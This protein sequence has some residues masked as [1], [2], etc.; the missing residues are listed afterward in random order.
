MVPVQ[1]SELTILLSLVRCGRRAANGGGNQGQK[2]EWRVIPWKVFWTVYVGAA[3]NP[4]AQRAQNKGP[5]GGAATILG[6]NSPLGPGSRLH[7]SC[8]QHDVE[9]GEP[10]ANGKEE[11]SVETRY[12]ACGI[13][14]AKLTRK[15]KRLAIRL[16]RLTLEACRT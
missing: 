12:S 13:A 5:P 3:P 8:R 2:G 11:S 14:A 7:D 6:Q 16:G 1:W 4:F 9:P 10:G 15:S